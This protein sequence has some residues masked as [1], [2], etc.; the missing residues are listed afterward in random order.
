MIKFYFQRILLKQYKL[1]IDTEYQ[2]ISILIPQYAEHYGNIAY[3][4]PQF[5]QVHRGLCVDKCIAD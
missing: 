4:E 5:L 2:L 1:I 3:G